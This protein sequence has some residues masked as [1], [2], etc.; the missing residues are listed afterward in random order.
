MIQI[1][2]LPD[3]SQVY[4]CKI[5][6]LKERQLIIVVILYLDFF[7][8]YETRRLKSISSRYITKLTVFGRFRFCTCNSFSGFLQGLESLK[9][10]SH[11]FN[12]RSA[13]FY[14]LYENCSIL[15]IIKSKII[16][17]N[18]ISDI[19]YI[20]KET[21]QWSWILHEINFV[22]FKIRIRHGD[23]LNIN[24]TTGNLLCCLWQESTIVLFSCVQKC[25]LKLFSSLIF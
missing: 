8:R 24:W 15:L 18:I 14:S 1:C 9:N 25:S 16:N 6:P 13:T 5:F 20:W 11:F 17:M 12:H 22:L 4:K 10:I 19:D 23:R 2:F 21:W 7:N 3:C